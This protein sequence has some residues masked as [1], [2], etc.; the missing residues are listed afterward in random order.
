MVR[1]FGVLFSMIGTA[2]AGSG[3]VAALVS[4]HVDAAS[5]VIAAAIGAGLALPVSWVIAKKLLG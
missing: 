3:V 1:L 2:M 5:I 4:G